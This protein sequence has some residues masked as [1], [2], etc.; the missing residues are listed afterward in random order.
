MI[1]EIAKGVQ[2]GLLCPFICSGLWLGSYSCAQSESTRAE[3]SMQSS[4]STSALWRAIGAI[5]VAG[6]P[7][8]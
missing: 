4:R 2:Q 6:K 5:D 3:T 8:G 1:V 7:V